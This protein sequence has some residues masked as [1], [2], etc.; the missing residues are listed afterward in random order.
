MMGWARSQVVDLVLLL[1]FLLPEG[2]VLLEELDDALGVTEVVLLELVDLVEGLLESHV[3]ELAG[4]LVVLHDFVVEDGEVK[5]KAELDGVAGSKGD[6]VGLL[7][8]FKS[9]QLDGL[10]LLTLGVLSEV[11]VVVA[12]H[13]DEEGLGLLGAGLAED[14]GVDHVD[15]A[16]AVSDELALNAGL[17]G[18]ESLSV[19]GVLGVLLDGGDGAAGGALGRDEV[20]EG[21]GEEVALV[22]GDIG[23][24]GVEDK[25][26]EVDHVFEALSLLSDAGEEYVF[27]NGG[28]MDS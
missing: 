25:G 13:L 17:V 28:H 20:L 10:E 4:S 23:T 24:L 27:F 6:L 18:G 19:L 11:A 1:V 22:G 2:E 16:L 7:V 5:G 14:L 15:D 8:G 12:D 9:V 3:G 26:E 21:D